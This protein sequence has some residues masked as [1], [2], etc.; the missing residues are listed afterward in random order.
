MKTPADT[1]PRVPPLATCQPVFQAYCAARGP[2]T[3][4][5]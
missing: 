2:L 3:E 1:G 5:G 4:E